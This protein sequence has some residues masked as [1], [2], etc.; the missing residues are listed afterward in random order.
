MKIAEKIW[1]PVRRAGVRV[2]GGKDASAPRRRTAPLPSILQTYGAFGSGSRAEL[3][4]KKTPEALRRFAETP[5]A[6]KAIK[7]QGPGG[8]YELAHPAAAGTGA[9]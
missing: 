7:R 5:I 4:P 3:L 6:R 9:G 1:E 2:L 8:G